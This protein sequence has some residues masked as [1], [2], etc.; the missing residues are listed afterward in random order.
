ME[1]TP[2]NKHME[3]EKEYFEACAHIFGY[4]KIK[5]MI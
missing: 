1:A 4:S 3:H 5:K 2:Q